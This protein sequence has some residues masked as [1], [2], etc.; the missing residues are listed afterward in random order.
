MTLTRRSFIA[1]TSAAA[2]AGTLSASR[3]V[4]AEN[5]R[6]SPAEFKRRLAGPIWS[7]PTPFRSNFEVDYD[8]IRNSIR[9][10]VRYGIPVFASTAGNSQYQSLTYDEIKQVTRVLV[11]AVDGQG[12]TI[13]ATGDWWT[14]QAIEYCRFAESVGADAVQVL[15]PSRHG[16]EESLTR[17]FSRI[18]ESTRLPVVLH[19]RFSETL[20]N[21]LVEIDSIVAMKEDVELTYYIDRMITFGDRLEI[22]GGGAENRFLVG[23]PYGSRSF[24]S[25]F[26]TFAPDISMRF[27]KAI[28][29]HD[30]KRAV[31]IT[32]TYDY[33]FIKGFTHP[34]WHATLEYFGLAQRYL[35][36]PQHS[37]SDEE[38]KTVQEFFDGLEVYP[39]DYL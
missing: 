25:T 26:S 4:P 3:A 17:H 11:E 39:K 24:F 33:P 37:F 8:G 32:T 7:N 38:M 27:W 2:A 19:G 1:M 9:R 31:E 23:Y 28:Q 18:A 36:P 29:A 10:A 14:G 6:L 22:F 15:S 35:R 34:F 21:R 16:G 12:L 5:T 13:G 30:L 20:L